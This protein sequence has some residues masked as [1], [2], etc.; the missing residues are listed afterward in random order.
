M[1][2]T[3]TTP[4]S[5][6][7]SEHHSSEAAHQSKSLSTSALSRKKISSTIQANKKLEKAVLKLHKARK[8]LGP[9]SILSL[10]CEFVE[11]RDKENKK[12]CINDC[13]GPAETSAMIKRKDN[14]ASLYEGCNMKDLR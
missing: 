3:L 5:P 11:R 8:S 9:M 12:K 7:I 6:P 4:A 2:S 1:S 10:A 14:V 13:K